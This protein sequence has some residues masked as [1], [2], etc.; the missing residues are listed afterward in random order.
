[1]SQYTL[2]IYRDETTS[3]GL[4]V[5]AYHPELPGCMAQGCTMVE[6]VRN[7]DHA[8]REYIASLLDD[9]LPVPP[10]RHSLFVTPLATCYMLEVEL[11][12]VH[13]A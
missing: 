9:N 7:L 12:S 8:R 10:P 13:N 5:V 11:E 2:A 3:G 4:C 1:M 6:A